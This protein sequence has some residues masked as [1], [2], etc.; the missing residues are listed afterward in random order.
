M[1]IFV[2]KLKIMARIIAKAIAI[3]IIAATAYVNS[4]TKPV[5]PSATYTPCGMHP[6]SVSNNIL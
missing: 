1:L 5:K 2:S 6:I 4:S 3:A